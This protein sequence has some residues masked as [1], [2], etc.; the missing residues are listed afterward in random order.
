VLPDERLDATI[1]TAWEATPQV[2]DLNDESQQ[3]SDALAFLRNGVQSLADQRSADAT[4][5]CA[6]RFE[7]VATWVKR[8]DPAAASDLAAVADE[9]RRLERL[10]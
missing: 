1:R 8:T 3:P 4:G 2:V 10:G 7:I 5:E 9:L 6:K